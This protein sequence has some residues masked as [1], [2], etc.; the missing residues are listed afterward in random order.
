MQ[1]Q[2]ILGNIELSELLQKASNAIVAEDLVLAK[3]LLNLILISTEDVNIKNH[4]V[5]ALYNTKINIFEDLKVQPVLPPFDNWTMS[6]L[7]VGTLLKLLKQ[8]K[9]NLVLELGSGISTILIAQK[10][11]E[12][13]GGSIITL[14]NGKEYAEITQD[15][16]SQNKLTNYAKILFA[17]L[18]AYETNIGQKYWYSKTKIPKNTKIDLLIVDGPPGNIQKDSRYP[19]IELLKDNLADKCLI[20]IDDYNREDEKNLVNKWLG[21]Y[22]Q[23]TIKEESNLLNGYALLQY[24]K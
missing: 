23:I 18:V 13:G 14:E 22:P 12:I 10:L 5:N 4:V 15:F 7:M 17:P 3:E 21:S 8:T 19:A 2:Q 16:V 6:P 1:N 24:K 11:K 9:P 20:Y